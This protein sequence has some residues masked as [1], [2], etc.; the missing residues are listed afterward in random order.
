MRPACESCKTLDVYVKKIVE[1]FRLWY[2]QYT[3]GCSKEELI[4]FA[5]K[6]LGW[7]K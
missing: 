4:E 2:P 7:G 6:E 5:T 3:S 1:S